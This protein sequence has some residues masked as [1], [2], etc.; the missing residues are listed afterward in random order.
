MGDHFDNLRAEAVAE[1]RERWPGA[2]I[3]HLCST[4][5][6]ARGLPGYTVRLCFGLTGRDRFRCW[7]T[8]EAPARLAIG[9]GRTSREAICE[10]MSKEADT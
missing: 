2:A 7:L 9:R 4:Q 10:A 1:L 5:V 3:D 8:T 6:M